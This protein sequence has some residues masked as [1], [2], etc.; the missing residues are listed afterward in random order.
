MLEDTVEEVA[1]ESTPQPVDA[2]ESAEVEQEAQPPEPG[3]IEYTKAVEERIGKITAKTYKAEAER[4]LYRQRLEALENAKKEPVAPKVDFTES[5]PQEH[6]FDDY[7][8]YVKSVASWQFR[9]ERAEYEAK[10]VQRDVQN[11]VAKLESDFKTRAEQSKILVEHP[12]FYER[13]SY[14]N[15]TPDLQEVL[16]T[17]EYG[18]QLALHLASN[19]ELMR[20]LNTVSPVVAAKKLGIIEAKISTNITKK[21]VSSAPDPLSPVN[22]DTAVKTEDNPKDINDWMKKRKER[23]LAKITQKVNGGR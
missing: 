10:S 18:P 3:S 13:I 16:L 14:I 9:K 7:T 5:E 15:V 4:D 11:R 21:K 20:E 2:A 22:T 17:S 19:P 8:S 23:E 1:E 12:D 6:D